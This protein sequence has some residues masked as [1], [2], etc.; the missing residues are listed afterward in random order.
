MGNRSQIHTSQRQHLDLNSER[1]KNAM[2]DLEGTGRWALSIPHQ[3][4]HGRKWPVCLCE[5]CL[6]QHNPALNSPDRETQNKA[7][8]AFI[9][10]GESIPYRV[11]DKA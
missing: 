9:K 2:R 4:D 10:S 6:Y 1:R 11:R 7:W 3:H 8:L 5:A